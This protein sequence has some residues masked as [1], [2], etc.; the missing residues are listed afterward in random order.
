[1]CKEESYEVE[2]NV[3]E[4]NIKGLTLPPKLLSEPILNS[5][6]YSKKG[7]KINIDLQVMVDRTLMFRTFNHKAPLG[8]THSSH[9]LGLGNLRERLNLNYPQKHQ[10]DIKETESTFELTL[11][12]SL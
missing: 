3:S 10:L 12:I 1:M 9:E 2:W 8:S 5:L 7:E 6:K 11:I 4:E